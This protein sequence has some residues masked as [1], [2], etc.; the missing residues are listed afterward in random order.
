MCIVRTRVINWFEGL[1]V[2]NE[3]DVANE[4]LIGEV[5]KVKFRRRYTRFALH[6]TCHDVAYI[7]LIASTFRWN[8]KKSNYNKD[9]YRMLSSDGSWIRVWRCTII[10]EPFYLQLIC[11]TYIKIYIYHLGSW[12][13]SSFPF[14]NNV[15]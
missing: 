15:S 2:C 9:D 1:I 7:Y 12:E 13:R 14:Q 5:E 6:C 4:G 10:S 11:F 3:P 8:V